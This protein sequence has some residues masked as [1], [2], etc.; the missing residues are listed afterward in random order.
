MGDLQCWFP[1]IFVLLACVFPGMRSRAQIFMRTFGRGL[2]QTA[3]EDSRRRNNG[4]E[5][6]FSRKAHAAKTVYR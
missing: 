1:I 3:V 5:A 4:V 6:G 2:L